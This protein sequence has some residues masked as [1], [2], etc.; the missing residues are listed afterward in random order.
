[1]HKIRQEYDLKKI[2]LALLLVL[3]IVGG[4]FAGLMLVRGRIDIRNRA[5]NSC[6]A[7]SLQNITCEFT[8]NSSVPFT[9]VVSVTSASSTAS[10]DGSGGPFTISSEEKSMTPAGTTTTL[11]EVVPNVPFTGNYTCSVKVAATVTNTCGTVT[12]NDEKSSTV[13]C[14]PPGDGGPQITP[15]TDG[16][17]GPTC[18]SC[19]RVDIELNFDNKNGGPIPTLTPPSIQ[20]ADLKIGRL[21]VRFAAECGVNASCANVRKIEFRAYNNATCEGPDPDLTPIPL[22]SSD[23]PIEYGRYGS[24]IKCS[25]AD[26][27]PGA[28]FRIHQASGDQCRCYKANIEFNDDPESPPICPKF[29]TTTVCCSTECKAPEI[30]ESLDPNDHTD[31]CSTDLLPVDQRC[32]FDPA[33][34]CPSVNATANF[35]VDTGGSGGNLGVDDD[36][37]GAENGQDIPIPAG[38]DGDYDYRYPDAGSYDVKLT[39]NNGKTCTKRIRVKCGNPPGNPPPGNPPGGGG[40]GGTPPIACVVPDISGSCED[41]PIQ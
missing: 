16:G 6:P 18:P 14:T 40:G 22:N 5:A 27:D 8:V 4:I 33:P 39:C 21:R 31:D 36:F 19:S 41:Q 3:V 10:T 25:E 34:Q 15:P 1:M 2:S 37:R 29:P 38:S 28:L 11:T 35:G 26:K 7:G 23:G 32:N 9:Y 20:D 13:T 24:S 30:I 12:M 17:S